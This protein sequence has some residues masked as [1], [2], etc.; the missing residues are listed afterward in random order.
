LAG[1]GRA[2]I[3]AGRLGGAFTEASVRSAEEIL[4]R[5]GVATV[6]DEKSTVALVAVSGPLRMN[7]NGVMTP[8]SV[9][10]A[11]GTFR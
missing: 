8:Y 5:N 1:V 4:A 6:A 3:P 11:L 10:C 7:F 9:L 2:A